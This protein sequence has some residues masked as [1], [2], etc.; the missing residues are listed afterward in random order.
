M[1][2]GRVVSVVIGSLVILI[3]LPLLFG[4][5]GILVL[6]GTF[7]DDEGFLTLDSIALHRDAFAVAAPA[8][9]M[10]D[11]GWSWMHPAT[12]RVEVEA[13]AAPG[14]VFVGVAPRDQ[15]EAYLK[16]VPY[17]EIDEFHFERGAG[18]AIEYEDRDGSGVAEAPTSQSFWRAS[19]MGTGRQTLQ[20]TMQPGDWV[21]VAMN[22]DG[23]RGVDFT[24]SIGVR[25]PWFHSIGI[26]LL[27]A[28]LVVFAIGLAIV[29]FVARRARAVSPTETKAISTTPTRSGEF[30]L[31]L[32]AEKDPVLSPALWLVKWF[33]LIP[34]W[35]VLGFLYIG[36][37][38]S[39]LISLIAILFTARY[40]RGLFDYNVGVLRWTWRVGYYG[41]QALATDR[42]PP[43]S[44]RAGGYPADLDVV[45]PE[46]LSPGLVLVKWWLLAIPHYMVVALLQGGGTVWRIGFVLVLS[47]FAG[48]TLLFTGK[49]PEDLWSLVVGMNRWT[50]RVFAYAALLTD[51]YP[52]FRLDE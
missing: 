52:P 26:G 27:V 25:A 18:K 33:L 11:W 39:W 47:V 30:P 3:A 20:W 1:S 7:G 43:F 8:T 46:R 2:A 6:E 31:T 48:V 38:V 29:L 28:G 40:P 14:I 36:F 44:M 19:A 35:V 23:T 34:H 51:A 10:G 22:A 16:D 21:L 9:I 13:A 41:Y 15:A 5:G 24:T 17:A 32:Q 49:Y 45:Y 42:Y 37:A 4:G 12:L 50:Y